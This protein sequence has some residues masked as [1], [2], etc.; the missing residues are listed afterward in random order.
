[1]PS[2]PGVAPKG[3]RDWPNVYAQHAEDDAVLEAVGDTVGRFLDIGAHDGAY[4]SNTLALVERGWSGVMV[5]A[6]PFIFARLVERHGGNPK[7]SLVNSAIGLSCR[8]VKLWPARIDDALSTTEPSQVTAREAQANFGTP[9]H[10]SMIPLLT[11]LAS[12]NG[13]VDA[14]SID[15]EG[16]SVDLLLA[17]PFGTITPKVVCVEHDGRRRE[18]REHLD[19]WD[20]R[21]VLENDE[22]LVFV[23]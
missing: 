1:M 8:V 2:T 14:L 5:E 18:C 3:F 10:V 9:F 21:V 19:R 22:N 12:F 4:L 17:F 13:P 11:L 6:N 23:R 7:L 15:T 16:T 20:Y